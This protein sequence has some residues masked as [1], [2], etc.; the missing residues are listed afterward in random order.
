MVVKLVVKIIDF[1]L[2]L[3]TILQPLYNHF[4]TKLCETTIFGCETTILVVFI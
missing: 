4:T 3:T 1:Y 2:V